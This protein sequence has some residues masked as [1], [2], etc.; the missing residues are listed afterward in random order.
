M[1]IFPSMNRI[2][3]MYQVKPILTDH[4]LDIPDL[5]AITE[6]NQDCSSASL[7]MD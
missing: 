6:L 2:H 3:V 1:S 4:K 7:F 5:N